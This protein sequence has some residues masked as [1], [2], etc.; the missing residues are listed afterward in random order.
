MTLTK[1]EQIILYDWIDRYV[2]PSKNMNYAIDTSDLRK[3]FVLYYAHGFY[4]SNNDMNEALRDKGYK[5]GKLSNDPYLVFNIANQCQ[6]LQEYRL[7]VSGAQHQCDP[8]YE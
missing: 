5:A 7:R 6:A 1:D 2:S 3:S 8:K 4:I